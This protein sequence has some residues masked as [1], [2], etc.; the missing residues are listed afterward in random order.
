[1]MG[2]TLRSEDGFK[3]GGK[4]GSYMGFIVGYMENIGKP[5]IWM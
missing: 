5:V 1:M 4:E 3:L 2:T